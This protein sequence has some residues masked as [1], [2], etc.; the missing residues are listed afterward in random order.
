M[1]IDT[2]V[3]KITVE[4]NVERVVNKYILTHGAGTVTSSDATSQSTYGLRELKESRTDINDGTTAQN[5]ADTYIAA[6]K[7]YKRKIRVTVNDNYDIE[8]IHAGHFLTINNSDYEINALQIQRIS[9]NIDKLEI[10][11]DEVTSLTQE[12]F[13]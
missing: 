5:T 10:E 6:N 9:Y 8:T 13:S 7:D 4:E 3:E 11:L 12:L 1:S 2:E